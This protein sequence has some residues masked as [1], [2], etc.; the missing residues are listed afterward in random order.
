MA[1]EAKRRHGSALDRALTLW[2]EA[3]DLATSAVPLSLDAQSTTFVLAGLVAA[4]A[5]SRP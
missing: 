5:E 1:M 2:S 4:M 3:R